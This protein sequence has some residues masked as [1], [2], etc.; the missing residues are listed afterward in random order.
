MR[1]HNVRIHPLFSVESMAE[2]HLQLMETGR[3][4]DMP[5]VPPGESK[6]RVR[7]DQMLKC[8]PPSVT[9]LVASTLSKRHASVRSSCLVR[10]EAPWCPN[11]G[12]S[13][14]GDL[15]LVKRQMKF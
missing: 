6:T 11:H 1:P 9:P 12:C 5:C 13:G 10:V 3:Q 15:H 2:M 14:T 8:I 4:S 7:F